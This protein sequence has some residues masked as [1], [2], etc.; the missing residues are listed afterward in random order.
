MSI[1]LKN[2]S[3]P[4]NIFEAHGLFCCTNMQ[5]AYENKSIF[6]HS[7]CYQACSIKE[8]NILLVWGSI[9]AKLIDLIKNYLAFMPKPRGVVHI[10]GCEHRIDNE[11]SSS[12]IG[13]FLPTDV[14]CSLC[15]FSAQNIDNLLNEARQCLKA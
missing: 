2:W 9:S 15:D 10:R 3:T 8:A 4:L 14:V 5:A 1:Q 11:V 13:Q 12:S 6:K 7:Y